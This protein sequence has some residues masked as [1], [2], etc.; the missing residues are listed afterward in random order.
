MTEESSKALGPVPRPLLVSPRRRASALLRDRLQDAGRRLL[1]M[2]GLF[3]TRLTPV[4]EIRGLLRDLAPIHPG[5]DLI[6]LGPDGDGGYLVPDDLDGIEACFSPGVSHTS[7]FERDC[8]ERGMQVFLADASVAGPAEPHP[9]FH[10]TPKHVGAVAGERRMTMEEWVGVALPAERGDLML[11][12]DIEGDEYEVLLSMPQSLLA[13]FRVI[14][15]ELHELDHLW[16]RRL[17]RFVA[18]AMRKVVSGHAC[19]HIHPNNSCAC[20]SMNG[21]EIPPVAEFTFLRTD[22]VR[23]RTAA[24]SFPHPL[25][26]PN[27]DGSDVPLPDCW[28]RTP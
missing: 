12:M 27:T 22:R 8:A 5:I 6:R 13:R 3:P 20:F 11:Q 17:F 4:E 28:C 15:V 24:R 16:N 2:A 19:V 26:R 18:A 21:V 1:A 23:A 9:R 25:D 10:F 7:G 14:V